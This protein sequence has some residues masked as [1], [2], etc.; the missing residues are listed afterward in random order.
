MFQIR[1]Q[2]RQGTMCAPTA[3]SWKS[4]FLCFRAS[5]RERRRSRHDLAVSSGQSIAYYSR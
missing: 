1:K 4:E 5:F 2:N 3:S